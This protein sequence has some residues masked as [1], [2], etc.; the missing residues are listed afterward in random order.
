MDPGGRG[1]TGAERLT[2]EET[3]S[4]YGRYDKVIAVGSLSKAYGLPG[5]ASAGPA[6]PVATLS[7]TSGRG[8]STSP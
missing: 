6:R 1:V 2:D 5:C 4:F 3:P 8:T 7:T